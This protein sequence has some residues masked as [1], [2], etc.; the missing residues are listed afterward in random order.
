MHVIVSKTSLTKLGLLLTFLMV[1]FFQASCMDREEAVETSSTHSSLDLTGDSVVLECS[2]GEARSGRCS[3]IINVT[4][5]K[6]CSNGN[7]DACYSYEQAV[8]RRVDT[9]N[10]LKEF[11][12]NMRILWQ[13]SG[14]SCRSLANSR[15]GSHF[16]N[17]IRG[18][19]FIKSDQEAAT[20]QFGGAA[21]IPTSC[22]NVPGFPGCQVCG[23]GTP[24]Y[25][26]Q[27]P[28]SQ[29]RWYQCH[30]CSTGFKLTQKVAPYSSSVVIDCKINDGGRP[31]VR[32][33]S[34]NNFNAKTTKKYA[35]VCDRPEGCNPALAGYYMPQGTHR[36]ID[37]YAA[38]HWSNLHYNETGRKFFG[39]CY[40]YW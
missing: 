33:T 27:L 24:N 2:C 21:L 8:G 29:K 20:K 19:D 1:G 34:H 4:E 26:S 31:Y 36:F 17:S 23:P 25:N 35:C 30:S 3:E 38:Y 18:D 11:E 14:G 12:N 28:T 15:D 5:A 40:N 9:L 13:G 10:R 39:S 22:E 7:A 37:D 32:S 6:R 16:H